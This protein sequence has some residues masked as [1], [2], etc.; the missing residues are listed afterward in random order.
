MPLMHESSLRALGPSVLWTVAS[1]PDN[2]D[3]PN[4]SESV[5]YRAARSLRILIVEDEILIAL[6]LRNLVEESGHVVVGIVESADYATATATRER[7]DVVLMDIALAG[8]RDGIDAALELRARLD[9]PSLFVSAHPDL[10]LRRRAEA[11]KPV[12]FLTKPVDE[13][14]LRRHLAR[15]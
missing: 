13:D 14:V 3:A 10:S 7:P 12:G 6:D 8:P 9:I 2:S 5:P 1:L 15:L 4:G 11:A